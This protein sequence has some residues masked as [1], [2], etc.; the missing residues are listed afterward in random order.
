MTV[1]FIV[2]EF[3]KIYV[4]IKPSARTKKE[5]KK[6]EERNKI[7]KSKIKETKNAL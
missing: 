2:F 4:K 6:K 7:D 5:N 3:W 1:I